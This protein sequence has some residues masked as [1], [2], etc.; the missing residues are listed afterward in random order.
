M[1]K[2]ELLRFCWFTPLETIAKPGNNKMSLTGFTFVE[3]MLVIVL[4][5]VMVLLASPRFRSTFGKLE[6]INFSKKLSSLMRYAQSR[7]IGEREKLYLVYKT[8]SS[9]SFFSLERD[10]PLEKKRMP[11]KGRYRLSVGSSIKIEMEGNIVVFYPDSSI[12]GQE[13][14]I[15]NDFQKSKIITTG[16]G[17]GRIYIEFP[18]E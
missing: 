2:D 11:L 1:K 5:A 3:L 4:I 13:I 18:E 16:G 8:D 14:I 12:E 15:Y 10:D 7:A 6:V 9:G 17:I